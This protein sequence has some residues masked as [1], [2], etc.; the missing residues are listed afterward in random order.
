MAREV[1]EAV[2]V[3]GRQRMGVMVMRVPSGDKYDERGSE[4]QYQDHG[5][6]S[7]CGYQQHISGPAIGPGPTCTLFYDNLNDLRPHITGQVPHIDR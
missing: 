1:M 7:H 6:S 3:A 2:M 4:Q 5:G